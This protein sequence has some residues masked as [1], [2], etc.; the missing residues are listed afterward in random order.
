MARS[1]SD[2]DRS[3][4]G[5]RLGCGSCLGGCAATLVLLVALAAVLWALLSCVGP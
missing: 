5:P 4:R 3:G 2:L 1:S